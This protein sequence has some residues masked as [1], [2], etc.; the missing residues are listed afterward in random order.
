ML[1]KIMYYVKLYFFKKKFRKLNK[2][3]YIYPKNIFPLNKVR[4]GKYSYGQLNVYFW[5]AENEKLIIGNFVSIA[6]GVKFVLGGNHYYNTLSTYPFKVKFL[7]YENEAWSK[8][9]I[10]IEDDVWI[11]MDVSIMS[12]VKIGKGAVVAARSVVTKD[13]PPYAIV[14][15]NPARIIKYRFEKEMIDKIKD[16]DLIKLIENGFIKENINLL[17]N[18]LDN[19][20]IIK[21]RRLC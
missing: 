12:G 17:Y 19:D 5:N 11:G 3:N 21:I 1:K 16:I 10:I 13:I 7:G 9:P 15:G 2:H 20:I 8:G 18:N 4:I 6:E 14:A